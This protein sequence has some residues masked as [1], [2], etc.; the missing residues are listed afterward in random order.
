MSG[1]DN[2]TLSKRATEKWFLSRM[3]RIS[4]TAKKSNETVLR[5]IRVDTI[6]SLINTICKLWVTFLGYGLRREKLYHLV[7][8]KMI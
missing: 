4:W 3:L 6:R 8:I 2:E 7:T 5:D 1:C